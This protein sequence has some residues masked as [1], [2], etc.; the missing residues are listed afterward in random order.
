MDFR[1]FFENYEEDIK[2]TLSKLPKG[3]QDLIKGY[4]FKFQPGNTL[5][6]DN[7]HIG[8]TDEEKKTITICAP[9]FYPREFTLCHELAH[10][11]WA[12]L[13][14]KQKKK[15]ADIIKK[16]KMEKKDRQN[17]EELFC[18]AY[19]ATYVKHPPTTFAHETWINFI[20]SL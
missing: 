17:D 16:T 6:G 9:W 18:H 11:V 4:K 20:K 10:K 3:H 14:E 8:V 12:T 13:S 7:G 1:Q 19:G 5:K 2:Q 15:W